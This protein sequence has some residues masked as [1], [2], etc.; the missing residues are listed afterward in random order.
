M[1]MRNK[2]YCIY[3]AFRNIQNAAGG[4]SISFRL[5][6]ASYSSA[7]KCGCSFCTRRRQE[8]DQ[9]LKQ[10]LERLYRQAAQNRQIR[11]KKEAEYQKTVR[12]LNLMNANW[13]VG[14][15]KW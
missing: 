7:S 4:S 13:Q 5:A 8:T 2:D 1:M 14:P 10:S 3:S 12:L 11:E 9:Q 6:A 15:R